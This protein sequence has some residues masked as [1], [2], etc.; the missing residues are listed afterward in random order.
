[1]ETLFMSSLFRSCFLIPSLPASVCVRLVLFIL[2]L[3]P[4]ATSHIIN[5]LH[6]P[7]SPLIYA[8]TMLPLLRVGFFFHSE[9]KYGNR[10]SQS[11]S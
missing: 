11:L 3:G 4:R 5:P 2:P 6:S 10:V 7:P 1:M 9:I 8:V